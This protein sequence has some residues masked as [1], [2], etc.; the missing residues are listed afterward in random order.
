MSLIGTNIRKLLGKCNDDEAELLEELLN[1][2]MDALGSPLPEDGVL[3]LWNTML[4]EDETR[5]CMG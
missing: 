4:G 5:R 3:C 2:G 1:A